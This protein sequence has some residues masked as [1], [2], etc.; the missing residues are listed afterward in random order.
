MNTFIMLIGL[1]GCGKSTYAK[2]LSANN[3]YVVHS[4]DEIRKVLNLYSY[5]DNEKSIIFETMLK[6]IKADMNEGKNI[7]VDATNLSR[8]HRMHYLAQIKK[9][10]NYEKICYLFIVPTNICEAQNRNRT[11]NNRVPNIVYDKLLKSFNT[12]MINEG[13]DKIIPI[14][15]TEHFS[16]SYDFSFLNN[17][18]QD[19]TKH[20]LTLGKHMNKAFEYVTMHCDSI[21]N[22]INL[23]IATKYHDIG[24]LYTKTFVNSKNEITENAHYYGHENYGAYQYLI[25]WLANRDIN[26]LTF[27]DAL[28]ISQLINWH[29]APFTRWNNEKRLNRDLKLIGED[30]YK[31]VMIM[32]EADK[33]AH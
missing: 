27:R 5:E 23:L 32:H 33:Y 20:N 26:G 6:N 2:K 15:Y 8:K 29:M 10:D 16:L 13:W 1:P 17:V 31:K 14:T 22:N 3:K 7:I 21:L 30:F 12:P 24:K 11:L 28:E 25:Y 9:F 19:S 18:N 4:S